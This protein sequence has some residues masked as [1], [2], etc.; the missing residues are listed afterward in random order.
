MENML[1]A[2]YQLLPYV[3]AIFSYCA[4][5]LHDSPLALITT[6]LWCEL[7]LILEQEL[8][9][10][11]QARNVLTREELNRIEYFKNQ[12]Y[13]LFTEPLSSHGL[14]IDSKYFRMPEAVRVNRILATYRL[15]SEAL[16]KAYSEMVTLCCCFPPLGS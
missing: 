13:A 14:G 9:P 2:D 7:C 8:L 10:K 12:I 5:Y 15:S 4:I 3:D 6:R 11:R 16:A 1:T